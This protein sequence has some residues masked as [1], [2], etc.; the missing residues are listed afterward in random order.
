MAERNKHGLARYIPADISRVVRQSCGFGCVICG[1]AIVEYEHVEPTFAEATEHD[2]R[3]IALLCPQCHAKVTRGFMPKETVSAALANPI[4]LSQGFARERFDFAGRCP[5]LVFAGLTLRDCPIPIAVNRV[6]M[7]K[8]EAGE[9]DGAPVRLS[10][11]FYNANGRPSLE[12]V[13]NEWRPLSG[14]WDVEATGGRI[15]VRD[16][17]RMI[18]L[19][20]RLA[21]PREIV[22]EALDMIVEGFRLV[23]S[24]TRLEVGPIGEKPQSMAGAIASGCDIGLSLV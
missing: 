24:A 15:I 18:S 12:I 14:N 23:G 5:D 11:N 1:S 22:V 7:L 19:Q 8:F 4:C 17:P 6:P 13:E 10:G 2:P 9:E 3:R 21:P 16:G 20:L